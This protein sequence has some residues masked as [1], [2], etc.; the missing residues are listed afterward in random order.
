MDGIA[1]FMGQTLQIYAFTC[2]GSNSLNLFSIVTGLS[3]IF[4]SYHIASLNSLDELSANSAYPLKKSGSFCSLIFKN[5]KQVFLK[6]RIFEKF[7]QG[8]VH[9]EGVIL[10]NIYTVYDTGVFTCAVYSQTSRF[11]QH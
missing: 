3:Q 9:Y 1:V 6:D 8:K 11:E 4:I 2:Y 10:L 5:F 7:F